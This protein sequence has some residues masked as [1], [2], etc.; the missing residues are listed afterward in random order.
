MTYWEQFLIQVVFSYLASIGYGLTINIPHRAL[1]AAGI[2]GTIGW[3]TFWILD[4]NESL[5]RAIPNLVGSF[6]L[7][8]LAYLLA[9]KKKCPAP[10][11]MIPALVPLVP[12]LPAYQAIKA[13]IGGHSI[14]ALRL[15]VKVCVVTGAIAVGILLSTILIEIL[16]LHTWKKHL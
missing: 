10:I 15:I 6:I 12:G 8:T 4:Y 16:N 2:T 1:N 14:L 11:F 5:G 3:M 7:A 9:K 13:L